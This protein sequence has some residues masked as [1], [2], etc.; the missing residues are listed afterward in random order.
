MG[1]G[2]NTD[3]AEKII[4]DLT[5]LFGTKEGCE[6][7]CRRLKPVLVNRSAEAIMTSPDVLSI[8]KNVVLAWD[9]VEPKMPP[10]EWK[11]DEVKLWHEAF[12][13][14]YNSIGLITKALNF[15]IAHIQNVLSNNN[16]PDVNVLGDGPP[17]EYDV[18]ELSVHDDGFDYSEPSEKKST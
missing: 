16:V 12:Y 5:D 18:G 15:I 17:R 13:S 14:G 10:Y 2:I 11:D 8:A 1:K 7:I 9:E 6:E 4:V 3:R